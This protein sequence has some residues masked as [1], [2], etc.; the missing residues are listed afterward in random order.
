VPLN[1]SW[2]VALH[3]T[4]RGLATGMLSHRRREFAIEFDL[5]DHVLAIRTSDGAA[6]TLPLAPRPVAD[7]YRELMS[8]L[9]EMA[10][11]VKIWPVAVEVPVPFRLDEDVEHRSY[12]PVYANRV[13]RILVRAERVLAAARRDFVGK[14]SPVHFFWGSFDLAVTR[15]SGRPAPP[16]EGPAFMRE[17]YSHEVIS[18]G[19]WP[20]GGPVPEP[21]FYAYAAPEPAGLAKAD[22]R[23][24]AAYY[25]HELGEFLLPYD[26][27]R[28]AGDP[29]AALT[30][31][32]Q[33]T[34]ERAAE[35]AGW[36]RHA[37]ERAP[38][39]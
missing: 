15:F 23:P 9:G 30:A 35:L 34:Y 3:V 32:V 26:A 25:H 13:W 38:A 6:R 10:L 28:T 18:H 11:P 22:V 31:F 14:C 39:S 37:L 27:V 20:G 2:G 16:R 21:V 7:F 36:D 8:T 29:D 5:V 19:F 17:S 12:D 24:S 33:S 4:A 1:H